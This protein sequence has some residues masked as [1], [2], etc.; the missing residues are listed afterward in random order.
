MTNPSIHFL[1]QEIP[2][3]LKHRMLMFCKQLCLSLPIS[4]LS[5]C[6]TNVLLYIKRLAQG[7]DYTGVLGITTLINIYSNALHWT[8]KHSWLIRKYDWNQWG[9]WELWSHSLVVYWIN[10]SE[11][12]NTRDH[13]VSISRLVGLHLSTKLWA[14]RH[15]NMGVVFVEDIDTPQILAKHIPKLP[16]I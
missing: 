6:P 9:N 1:N 5:F 16:S 2:I 7:L 11:I 10:R 3:A 4:F 13:L 12:V 14:H 15:F 8:F